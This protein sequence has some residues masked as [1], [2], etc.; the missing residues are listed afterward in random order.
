[1]KVRYFTIFLLLT[2]LPS[3]AR[4][5]DLLAYETEFYTIHTDLPADAVR[6][7]RIRM[8]K[9]AGEYIERTRGFSGVL[10]GRM[11]FYLYGN[12]DAYHAAGMPKNVAGMFNGRI[13]IA[14]A[15]DMGPRTWSTVQHEGFHQFAHQV[16]RGDL[17]M[18]VDEGLAEYFG[19]AVFTGDGFVSGVIPQWRLK[20][21]R[22]TFDAKK[23]RPLREIMEINRDDW[24][25]NLAVTNYDQAWSMVQFLAHGEGGK[26]QRALGQFI[27]L[28]GDNRPW[29]QA[30]RDTFGDVQGFESKWKDFW[31]GLPDNPTLE[32][33]A[34]S[35]LATLT[36][37]LAR[38][39]S[40]QQRF[41]DFVAFEKAATEGT[42]KSHPQDWLPPALL[43]QAFD[44]SKVLAR[45]GFVYSITTRRGETVPQ[46]TC[47]LPTGKT[48]VGKFT[49]RNGRIGPVSVDVLNPPSR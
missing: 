37:F 4:A 34:R 39:I 29:E 47:K 22:E 1:M 11:P 33:Y 9:M 36:S 21:I 16:I 24:N 45:A 15:Q 40:Q 27:G 25:S 2:S 20:R 41:D 26:Y 17:P 38:A 44:Q 14:L 28:I 42:L 19:E 6:E 23:F 12:A 3:I 31:T 8:T 18:W 43:K 48:L 13:L 46:L 7:A 49:L 35:N 10:N 30:W 5:Q 32:L